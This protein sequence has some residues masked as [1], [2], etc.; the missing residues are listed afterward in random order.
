MLV[1]IKLHAEDKKRPEDFMAELAK[2]TETAGG[3]TTDRI[4]Q[5]VKQINPAYLIGKGK[6]EEI[7]NLVS[8][9]DADLVIFDDDLTPAQQRNLEEEFGVKVID[10]TGLILDIFAQRAKSKEGK[11]QVQLAQLNYLLP[12]LVGWGGVLSRLGGGIGT[13]GP[14]ETKLE[15][16]RRTIR[17]R[18]VRAKKDIEKVRKVRTLHRKRRSHISCSTV[19]FIGYT[20]A[21]KSTL[22][23]YL[24]NAG[25]LV[26]D[27]LF[28]TLDPT[29]RKI[30]LPDNREILISDTVGFINKLP[31]QLIAAFKATLEEINESD[32]LLHVVDISH[33][34]VDDHITSVNTVLREIGTSQKPIIHALNK[35]DKLDNVNSIVR[36][37]QRE[38][39]NCVAVSALTGQGI[40]DLFNKIEDLIQTRLKKVKLKLPVDAG[41]IISKIHRSGRIIREEYTGEEVIIEAEVD[42]KLAHSLEAFNF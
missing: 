1:G 29:I 27:K 9:R 12:R 32:I 25:V 7:K 16:D 41:D 23:N 10:R 5:E 8:Q 17:D 24:S 34:R 19:S 38:L 37:W 42:N 28:A 14:G 33:P 31:H 21:G 40:N 11:L 15:V 3:V 4:I 26:G 6:V 18:I 30:R 20:N 22:L 13:R 2:L 35:I 39:D 36:Y